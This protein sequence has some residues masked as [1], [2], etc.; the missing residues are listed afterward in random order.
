MK[1]FFNRRSTAVIVTA[2]VLAAVVV[3]LAV[4]QRGRAYD[5]YD[6]ERSFS[7]SGASSQRFISFSGGLMSY[8]RDGAQ[9]YDADG[10]TV[11]NDSFNMRS[12]V[13]QTS[14]K[15]VLIY[16]RQGNTIVVLSDK[17]ELAVISTTHPIVMAAVA[18][19][20]VSAVLTQ[21]GDTGYISLY[22]EDS[23]TL[24]NGQ[25]HL[26]QTGYPMSMAL[27]EDGS[28]LIMSF[29]MVKQ[30]ALAARINVYDFTDQGNQ[31]KDNVIATFDYDDTVI[32]E[33]HFFSDGTAVAVTD[34]GA[35]IYSSGT[36]VKE[37]KAVKA[38]FQI[39]KVILSGDHF[40]L[41]HGTK[42]SGHAVSVYDERGEQS[43][44]KKLPGTYDRCDFIRDD[45]L[46]EKAGNK[47]SFFDTDGKTRFSYSFPDEIIALEAAG[48]D[49]EYFLIQQDTSQVIRI[50]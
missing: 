10:N 26:S 7:I 28:R 24:A 45:L 33:T 39:E 11:W 16:D 19:D 6:V 15:R 43:C 49:R 20:G 30:N 35:R 34:S 18:S 36:E 14:G 3:I 2:A 22:R 31:K 27:S 8:S 32:P 23:T 29:S 21:E 37:T 1:S 46:I 9:Y 13:V 48:E 38:G 40:G 5:T 4:W 42:D 41:I 47:V 25:V 44:T 50:S 17:K 12:P